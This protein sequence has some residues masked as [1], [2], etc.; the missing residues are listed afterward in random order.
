[1]DIR[2]L[3]DPAPPV[4]RVGRPLGSPPS[5][6]SSKPLIPVG[7]FSKPAELNWV[8]LFPAIIMPRFYVIRFFFA[9]YPSDWLLL[10]GLFCKSLDQKWLIEQV[11]G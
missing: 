4:I 11:H 2:V 10:R 9:C 6:I 7:D 8:A 5:V 1:M 3:P